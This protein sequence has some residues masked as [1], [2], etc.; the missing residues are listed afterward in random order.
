MGN[1]NKKIKNLSTTS[2][3][4]AVL[5]VSAVTAVP[6]V[7]AATA[8][9]TVLEDNTKKRLPVVEEVYDEMRCNYCNSYSHYPEPRCQ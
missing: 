1:S 5:A 7:P 2:D 3:V 6:A 9:I 4:S 8:A